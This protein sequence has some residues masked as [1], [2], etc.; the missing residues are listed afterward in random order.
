VRR[1]ALREIMDRLGALVLHRPA[2][3][4]WYTGGADN[5]VDHAAALG[6]AGILL[7]AGLEVLEHPWYEDPGDLIRDLADGA[8]VGT[9]S[10][11]TPDR[12]S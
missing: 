10:F 11:W 2:N 9:D 1:E 7:T 4:A 3:F 5:R 12:R 6:V 8:S